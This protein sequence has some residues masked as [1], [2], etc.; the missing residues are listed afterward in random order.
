M[1]LL[2]E[3]SNLAAALKKNDHEMI[4]VSE[5]VPEGSFAMKILGDSMSP[6]F[7]PGDY[8]IFSSKRKPKAGDYVAAVLEKPKAAPEGTFRR[9]VVTSIDADGD[10]VF[11]LHPINPVYP[12]LFSKQNKLTIVGV[13]IEHR[14]MY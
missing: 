13:L 2:E 14:R 6:D 4:D 9:Y 3:I 1:L 8:I 5:N 11:E 12:K 7:L 10:D